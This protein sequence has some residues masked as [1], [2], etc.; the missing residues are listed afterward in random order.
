MA[1]WD[2][3]RQRAK[4][5]RQS[6]TA[7]EQILWD[8]LRNRGLCGMKFRRQ[9]PVGPYIAD[10]FCHEHRL[11]VELDGG[12]HAAQ[13]EQDRQRAEQLAAHGYRVLRYSNQAVEHDLEAVLSKIAAACG[14]AA[15]LPGVVGEGQA[16]PG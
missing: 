12:I 9:H 15:L 14:A 16:E 13:G 8:R 4:E 1:K 5:L 3:V 10:F 7:A 6:Q 2:R 11:I